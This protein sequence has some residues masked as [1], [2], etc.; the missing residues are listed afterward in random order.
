MHQF[1]L[2]AQGRG[3]DVAREFCFNGI[4]RDK[5]SRYARR[6]R[7]RCLSQTSRSA[8]AHHAEEAFVTGTFGGITP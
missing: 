6:T 7:F 5:S 8:D 3:V 1:L 4:T 2:R